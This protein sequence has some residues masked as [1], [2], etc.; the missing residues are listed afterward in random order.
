MEA[1]RLRIPHGRRSRLVTRRAAH[2]ESWATQLRWFAAA[3]LVSF[4]VPFIGSSVLGLQHDLY[5]A[6]Y[7][8]VVLAGFAAYAAATELD[9]GATLRRQWKLGVGLGIIFGVLLVRNVFSE[10]ATPRPH[11]AYFLFELIWRGGIYGAVDALLLTVLPCLVVY[12]AL[13]GHLGTWGRRIAY[14]GASLALVMTITA[15]YHLGFSQYRQDGVGAP[16]TGNTII[17]LPMLLSTNPIG[18]VADHMA[19]HIAAVA[20]TYETDVRLPPPAKAR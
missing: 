2:P 17:S 1:H 18:S 6:I 16:E 11:G 9:V 3:A 15:I 4:S 20:R 10:G 5:L 7:F 19:M 8:V 13:G 12:R 14:F